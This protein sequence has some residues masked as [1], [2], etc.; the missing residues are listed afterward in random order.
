[1]KGT[2]NKSKN[3]ILISLSSHKSISKYVEFVIVIHE[4]ATQDPHTTFFKSDSFLC[5]GL[6]RVPRSID[7]NTVVYQDGP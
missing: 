6:P 3:P 4:N 2:K 1:V 5:A 7:E